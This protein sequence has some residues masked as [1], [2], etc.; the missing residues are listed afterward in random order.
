[1]EEETSA[2]CLSSI[3]VDVSVGNTKRHNKVSTQPKQMKGS[4]RNWN[5]KCGCCTLARLIYNQDRFGFPHA[6]ARDRLIVVAHHPS[7]D[8]PIVS[9]V[10]PTK[11]YDSLAFNSTTRIEKKRA[12][13]LFKYSDSKKLFHQIYKVYLLVISSHVSRSVRSTIKTHDIQDDQ[14]MLRYVYAIF[15]KNI[16]IKRK[17]KKRQL[18]K[19]SLFDTGF[20]FFFYF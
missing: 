10:M 15:E 13:F 3:L 2:C 18:I 5:K 20:D 16:Y 17:R 19:C 9:D 14:S 6:S 1:M 7:L 8:I 12:R 4:A 11:V